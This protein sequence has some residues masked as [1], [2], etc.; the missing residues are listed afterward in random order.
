MAKKQNALI[1]L[2]SYMIY[3]EK[4]KLKNSIFLKPTKL[5]SNRIKVK[6]LKR[7]PP[8]HKGKKVKG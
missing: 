5:E 2:L 8:L 6:V 1:K 7:I 3:K 4:N